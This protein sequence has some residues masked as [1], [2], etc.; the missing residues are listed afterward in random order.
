VILS[1]RT[2][3]KLFSWK[4]TVNNKNVEEDVKS[5]VRPGVAGRRLLWEWYFAKV[6]FG[7]G[8]I[9]IKQS[10]IY[11][12]FDFCFM[13][14]RIFWTPLNSFCWFSAF[15]FSISMVMYIII[16]IGI[17]ILLLFKNWIRPSLKIA[18]KVAHRFLSKIS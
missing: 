8:S 3:L 17:F 14:S 10:W 6:I 12:F 11:L 4:I 16:F 9:Y 15:W 18:A 1:L 2:L 13:M 7:L 5:I